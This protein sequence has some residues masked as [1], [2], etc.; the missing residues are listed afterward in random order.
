MMPATTTWP[1]YSGD[2]STISITVRESD[3]PAVLPESG[4]AAQ[5]RR[6][7]SA[8]EFETIG[9]DTTRAGEGVLT[10]RLTGEQT[11]AM[12]RGGVFDLEH[13]PSQRTYLQG[14]TTWTQDVTRD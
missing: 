11:T 13:T 1:L 7:R 4:W 9:I 2:A 14:A 3:A 8:T 5:W 6:S 10:L 12:G